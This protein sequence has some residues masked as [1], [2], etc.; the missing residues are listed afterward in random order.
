MIISLHGEQ[1]APVTS[2]NTTATASPPFWELEA[3]LATGCD[4]GTALTVIAARRAREAPLARWVHSDM[5][6]SPTMRRLAS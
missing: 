5:V 6:A 3:L 1:M 4:L 2:G